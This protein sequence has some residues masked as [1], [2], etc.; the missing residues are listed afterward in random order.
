MATST[1]K[2]QDFFPSQLV[3][4]ILQYQ[5]DSVVSFF[6][7]VMWLLIDAVDYPAVWNISENFTMELHFTEEYLKMVYIK[8]KRNW[9]CAIWS[10]VFLFSFSDNE[11]KKKLSK[12]RHIRDGKKK[13]SLKNVISEP[14]WLREKVRVHLNR[15]RVPRSLRRSGGW[16]YRSVKLFELKWHSVK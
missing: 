10:G 15:F 16:C 14:N 13:N 7:S 4:N 8:W 6:L 2:H 3:S 11:L 1:R 9:S 12:G 5:I